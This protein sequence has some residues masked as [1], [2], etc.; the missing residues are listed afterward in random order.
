MTQNIKEYIVNV[1]P[2]APLRPP[3]APAIQLILGGGV[4][5]SPSEHDPH[6]SFATDEALCRAQQEGRGRIIYDT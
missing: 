4:F 5:H 1:L 2:S 6:D 3:G